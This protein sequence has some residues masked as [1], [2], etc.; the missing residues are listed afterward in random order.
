M[1][2]GAHS[3]AP[4]SSVRGLTYARDGV[5]QASRP[6]NYFIGLAGGKPPKWKLTF[7]VP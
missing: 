5:P 6:H 1:R 3:G 7:K 2:A 4:A